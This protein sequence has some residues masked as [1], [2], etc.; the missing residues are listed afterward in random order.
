MKM[1]RDKPKFVIVIENGSIAEVYSNMEIEYGIVNYDHT[2][3]P[4][5]GVYVTELVICDLKEL[6]NPP[7]LYICE[8]PGLFAKIYNRLK[9]LKF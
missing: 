9:K 5:E 7:Q 2:S 1:E 8:N 4:V 6:W 3:K